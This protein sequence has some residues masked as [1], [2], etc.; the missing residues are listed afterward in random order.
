MTLTQ[1]EKFQLIGNMRRY[2]GNFVSKLADALAAADHTN[3]QRIYDAFPDVIDKYIAFGRLECT[4]P[5]DLAQD[6]HDQDQL[7]HD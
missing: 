5:S 3:A 2:G 7:R 6:C 4:T 1:Q